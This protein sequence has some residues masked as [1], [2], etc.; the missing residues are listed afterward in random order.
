[1]FGKT[2]PAIV[3]KEES[4]KKEDSLREMIMKIWASMPP[5]L[6]G[7]TNKD[8]KKNKDIIEKVLI[9]MGTSHNANYFL[10]TLSKQTGWKKGDRIKYFR[11]S[12]SGDLFMD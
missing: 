7:K 1:M 3:K 12:L 8:E 6:R 2:I 4:I 10:Q 5:E 9:E 11:K